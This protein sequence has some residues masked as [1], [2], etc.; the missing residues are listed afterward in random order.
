MT[1]QQRIAI[2]NYCLLVPENA[3]PIFG[4]RR[5][6]G[7]S[8]SLCVL[9]GDKCEYYGGPIWYCTVSGGGGH[10]RWL[11]KV[12]FKELSGVGDSS[13]GEWGEYATGP[14][15]YP[16]KVYELTRRLSPEEEKLIPPVKDIRG[17][18]EEKYRISRLVSEVGQKN[19]PPEYMK[20]FKEYIEENT[21]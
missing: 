5:E 18:D 19:L 2:E 20:Y 10:P 8:V 11:R 4:W 3:R 7:V 1:K 6:D 14:E 12:A 13:R 16:V 9:S 17:T 15:N 21:K